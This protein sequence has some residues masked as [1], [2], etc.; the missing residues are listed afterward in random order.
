LTNTGNRD[1]VKRKKKNL[2]K[3]AQNDI[4]VKSLFLEQ[5]AEAARNRKRVEGSPQKALR[6]NG[7]K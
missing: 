2:K 5:Q 6:N 3:S 4:D 7:N 1:K